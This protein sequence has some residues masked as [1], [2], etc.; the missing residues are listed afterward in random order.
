MGNV[1]LKKDPKLYIQDCKHKILPIEGQR[2][3]GNT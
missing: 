1:H 3:K 2:L